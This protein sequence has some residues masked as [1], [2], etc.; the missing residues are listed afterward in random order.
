[1]YF[2][3]YWSLQHLSNAILV[4]KESILFV[5]FTTMCYAK[6]PLVTA[7]ASQKITYHTIH[8]LQ[9]AQWKIGGFQSWHSNIHFQI[10]ITPAI[11]TL[12]LRVDTACNFGLAL[13][14]SALWESTLQRWLST[15]TLALQYLY[16]RHCTKY[17]RL[18]NP[19][20]IKLWQWIL[21]IPASTTICKCGFSKHN[22]V[23]SD[24]KSW[25]KLETLDALMRVSLCSLPM[26]SMDWVNKFDTHKLTKNWRTLPL[27]LDDD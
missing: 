4:I 11:L 12:H 22:W 20:T 7:K 10:P 16:N 19:T 23:K 13:W 15:T 5:C 3:K 17:V 25:L 9:F 26:E 14:E 6:F 18:Q 2:F 8:W 1:M 27:E 24:R 21:V